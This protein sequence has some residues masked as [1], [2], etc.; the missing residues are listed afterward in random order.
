MKDK[1]FK[2]WKH[3]QLIEMIYM[4]SKGNIS[5]RRIKI[6]KIHDKSFVA[7]CFLRKAKRTF[8]YENVLSYVPVIKREKEVI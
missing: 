2:S 1:L 6:V 7:F 5:K 8:Q 4:D 3:Q